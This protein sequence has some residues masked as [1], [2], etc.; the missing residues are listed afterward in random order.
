MRRFV[1]PTRI[2]APHAVASI[3]RRGDRRPLILVVV[4]ERRRVPSQLRNVAFPVAVRGYDRRAVD[5]YVARV[6]RV[7]AELE[8]THSPEAAIRHA[9]QQ[10]EE[11]T[12]G[13]LQKAEKQARGLTAAAQQEADEI[14]GRAKAEAADIVVNASTRADRTK[15]EADAYADQTKA[16]ADEQATKATAEAEGIIAT[17][18]KEA[19]EQLQRCRE[20]VASVRE[21]AEA[22][23]A[24][25][26]ADTDALWQERRALL[27]DVREL[28]ER[29]ST[30]AST[31]AARTSPDEPVE[32]A[33]V[34]ST[35]SKE[36]HTRG[37]G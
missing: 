4:R 1:A 11:Q 24:G 37:R 27:D 17:T 23:A 13:T 18:R 8:A 5:G 26:S 20:E 12:Q 30:A 3:S 34:R 15:L 28:A 2:Y 36:V 22:W 29:L 10:A 7:I 33:E 9:L 16:K 32:R 14:L 31:A 19:E 25:F 6:N 21:K 35:R